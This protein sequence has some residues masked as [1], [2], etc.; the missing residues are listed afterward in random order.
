M[1]IFIRF[2]SSVVAKGMRGVRT[3]PGG[4]LLGAVNGQF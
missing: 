3:A 1:N 2:I 4:N